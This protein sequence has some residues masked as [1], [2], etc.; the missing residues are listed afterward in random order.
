[1]K[2]SLF[3]LLLL[4]LSALCALSAQE[5]KRNSLIEYLINRQREVD[6]SWRWF[7]QDVRLYTNRLNKV[8][9]D[10]PIK[11][12]ALIP[13]Q[14]EL[15]A[16]NKNLESAQKEYSRVAPYIT[17]LQA[18][19]T[20]FAQTSGWQKLYVAAEYKHALNSLPPQY[21]AIL[22]QYN[23]SL[24]KFNNLF[25]DRIAVAQNAL[26]EVQSRYSPVY[27]EINKLQSEITRYTKEIAAATANAQRNK[28][29]Y[30][31]I[32]SDLSDLYKNKN[33]DELY[34]KYQ[35]YYGSQFNAV[36]LN[37]VDDESYEVDSYD[38]EMSN[39]DVEGYYQDEF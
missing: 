12:Q 27:N 15:D 20:K 19:E 9:N 11:Q 8:T 22:D 36:N 16:A 30:Y 5:R 13:L 38:A 23:G 39:N 4:T 31:Q 32:A 24:V 29:L 25:L 2:A 35:A 1:M 33:I 34:A 10:L 7:E 6:Q 28:D 14:Q 3:I 26:N 18:L 17:Q 21:K 37:F